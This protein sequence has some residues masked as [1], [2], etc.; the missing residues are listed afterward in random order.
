[1]NQREG[2]HRVFNGNAFEHH[3]PRRPRKWRRMLRALM[4]WL[5]APSPWSK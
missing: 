1:M 2:F 5:M 4:A 3:T